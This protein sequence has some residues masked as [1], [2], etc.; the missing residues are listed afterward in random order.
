MQDKTECLRVLGFGAARSPLKP[1][2]RQKTGVAAG[3][4]GSKVGDGINTPKSLCQVTSRPLTVPSAVRE[5][6][7]RVDGVNCGRN[8]WTGRG[9][10]VYCVNSC[11]L[12]SVVYS[13]SFIISAFFAYDKRRYASGTRRFLGCAGKKVLHW[14]Q[15][16]VSRSALVGRGMG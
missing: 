8:R 12:V 9:K 14:V 7:T 15:I 5:S 1:R 11:P 6:E 13:T 3:A 4:T 10:G 16:Q 2:S